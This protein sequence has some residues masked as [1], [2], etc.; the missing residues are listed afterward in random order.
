MQNAEKQVAQTLAN[1]PGMPEDPIHAQRIRAIG[2]ALEELPVSV[3]E[4][5]I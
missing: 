2:I 5:E 1:I 3:A 4:M